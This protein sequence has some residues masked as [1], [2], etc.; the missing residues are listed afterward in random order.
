MG[1]TP[2]A[3]TAPDDDE[4]TVDGCANRGEGPE[5]PGDDPRLAR[6]LSPVG[7]PGCGLEGALS[8]RALHLAG[9]RLVPAWTG[10]HRG[11]GRGDDT[12]SGRPARHAVAARLGLPLRLPVRDALPA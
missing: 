11:R 7:W 5:D 2:M 3:F 4:V 1:G 6:H 10:V 12:R 9:V 8:L